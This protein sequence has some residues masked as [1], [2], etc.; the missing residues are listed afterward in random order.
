MQSGCLSRLSGDDKIAREAYRLIGGTFVC[1]FVSVLFV[2]WMNVTRERIYLFTGE[3]QPTRG[4][5]LAAV[6]F[7]VVNM[8]VCSELSCE[9]NIF[10]ATSENHF[11]MFLIK[12]P[13]DR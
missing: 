5:Y 11:T 3:K 4:S 13:H 8:A 10:C 7:K 9:I 12:L 6:T 2:C 1:L